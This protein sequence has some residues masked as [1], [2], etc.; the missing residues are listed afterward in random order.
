MIDVLSFLEIDCESAA[1]ASRHSV[2]PQQSYVQ[3]REVAANPYLPGIR[4]PTFGQWLRIARQD[5]IQDVFDGA[6]M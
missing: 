4:R 2:I 3:E 6:D 1:R 5:A